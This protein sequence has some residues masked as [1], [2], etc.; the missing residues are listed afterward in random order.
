MNLVNMASGVAGVYL[1]SRTERLLASSE[2][3]EDMPWGHCRNDE[4][5]R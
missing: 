5:H 2:K 1:Q 3:S 4:V